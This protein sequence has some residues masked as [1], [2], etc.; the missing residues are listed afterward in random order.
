MSPL[1]ALK[2][3][4]TVRRASREH[5]MRKL[6]TMLDAVKEKDVFGTIS[7]LAAQIEELM[8]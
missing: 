7:I 1:A 5:R 4:A 6:H 8:R 3:H 2:F